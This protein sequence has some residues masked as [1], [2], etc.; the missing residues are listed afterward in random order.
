MIE[1][2]PRADK[3][4]ATIEEFAERAAQRSQHIQDGADF[5]DK[6]RQAIEASLKNLGELT[7]VGESLVEEGERTTA[8]TA[9]AAAAIAET[10]EDAKGDLASIKKYV[11]E[12]E[13]R[14]EKHAKLFARAEALELSLQTREERLAMIEAQAAQTLEHIRDLLP[15]A[16]TAGLAS[17]FESRRQSLHRSLVLWQSGAILSIV[18]LLGLALYDY[19][20]IIDP[21]LSLDHLGL[22]L[23][24][25]LPLIGPLLWLILYC[26]RQ[27]ATGKRVEE[28]YAFKASIS[29]SFEGYKTQLLEMEDELPENAPV[30]QLCRDTLVILST[31]PGRIYEKHRSDVTPLSE[32]TDAAPRLVKLFA[33]LKEASDVVKGMP[34]APRPPVDGV[35]NRLMLGFEV[36]KVGWASAHTVV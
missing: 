6:T 36:R 23:L 33:A 3:A 21:T 14:D 32:L 13:L 5:V 35:E 22:V 1:L 20:K 15:A 2:A 4:L 7:K 19:E 31:P 11:S 16:T 10:F 34:S 27:A 28:E 30:K 9:K 12:S 29:R 17:S 8:S 18:L 25:R 24:R 26:S